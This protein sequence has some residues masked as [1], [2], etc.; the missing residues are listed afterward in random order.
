MNRHDDEEVKL[1][2]KKYKPLAGLSVSV[3]PM[4]TTRRTWQQ[5]TRWAICFRQRVGVN[6]TGLERSNRTLRLSLTV[7]TLA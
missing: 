3:P 7:Y 1:T 2:F 4:T 6:W 5:K